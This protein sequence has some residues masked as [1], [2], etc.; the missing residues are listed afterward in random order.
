MAAILGLVKWTSYTFIS[1]VT[2]QLY[3]QHFYKY[4]YVILQFLYIILIYETW[5]SVK[6]FSSYK[7]SQN[8]G[9][10]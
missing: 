8:V 5:I 9:Y 6:H 2:Y 7:L 3:R 10:M 4:F 1:G